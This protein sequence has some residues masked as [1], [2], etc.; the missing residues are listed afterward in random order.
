MV[1]RG[2]LQPTAL[3]AH[4]RT[5]IVVAQPLGPAA[6]PVSRGALTFPL[7]TTSVHFPRFPRNSVLQR[8]SFQKRALGARNRASPPRGHSFFLALGLEEVTARVQSIRRR[9]RLSGRLQTATKTRCLGNWPAAG[10]H[11]GRWA[12]YRDLFRFFFSFQS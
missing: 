12:V 4:G 10:T 3:S 6:V 2:R 8:A 7:W 9:P 5:G 1:R 11:R